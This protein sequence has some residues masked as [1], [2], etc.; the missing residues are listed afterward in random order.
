MDD[1]HGRLTGF[2]LV[3]YDVT[4]VVSQ[5]HM[6][7]SHNRRLTKVPTTAQQQVVFVDTDDVLCIESQAHSTRVRTAQG[8]QFCNLSISDLQ[9]RLDPAQFQRVH[10]CFIVNLAAVES[11]AREG[12]RLHLTLHGQRDLRVPVSRTE[13]SAL[14]TAL[15]LGKG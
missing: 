12:S 13:A 4:Q 3:F 8:W 15:G 14:R 11:L 10:R 5:D 2:V 1:L 6:P 7:S 9:D